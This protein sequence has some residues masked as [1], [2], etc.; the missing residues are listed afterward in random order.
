MKAV[1]LTLHTVRESYL[2]RAGGWGICSYLVEWDSYGH[3]STDWVKATDEG[4][5]RG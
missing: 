3:E 5:A 1:W 4:G 2:T